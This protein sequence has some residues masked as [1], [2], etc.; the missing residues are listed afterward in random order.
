[1][2]I[3]LDDECEIISCR[4]RRS[5]SSSSEIIYVGCSPTKKSRKKRKQSLKKSD[6]AKTAEGTSLHISDGSENYF[7][8]DQVWSDISSI[9]KN[10]SCI[11]PKAE[12]TQ[13]SSFSATASSPSSSDEEDTRIRSSQEH[14]ETVKLMSNKMMNNQPSP[15]STNSSTSWFASSSTSSDS[16][17]NNDEFLLSLFTEDS[18]FGNNKATTKPTINSVLPADTCEAALHLKETESKPSSTT[19]H[20]R[21]NS[22][23][24]VSTDKYS[25]MSQLALV[26]TDLENL[27]NKCNSLK[28]NFNC[29]AGT[30][31]LSSNDITSE[32]SALSTA[33]FATICNNDD[34]NSKVPNAENFDQSLTKS[35]RNCM[36]IKITLRKAESES[37]SKRK[38]SSSGKRKRADST[39]ALP[40]DVSH[41]KVVDSTV[42]SDLLGS[43]SEQN[44]TE[45]NSSSNGM[46]EQNDSMIFR[47]SV[48]KSLCLH[49]NNIVSDILDGD[50]DDVQM[51]S[52]T[53][54]RKR[55]SMSKMCFAT[56]EDREQSGCASCFS[57][58]PRQSM[59]ACAF[60]HYSCIK[61][62]EYQIKSLVSQ[63]TKVI[64]LCVYLY[65]MFYY[66]IIVIT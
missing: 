52:H 49:D 26:K 29:H 38:N 54:P 62:L 30:S 8:S 51:I 22:D 10:D 9:I 58:F 60:G 6:C 31:V 44:V 45:V 21:I 53:L 42:C 66:D 25:G 7:N 5:S 1:M 41:Y 57:M 28:V 17:E 36:P 20:R 56:D 64:L 12:N 37:L 33:H 34:S 15:T 50:D 48:T 14:I 4:R 16:D 11:Q 23:G 40:S 32:P 18:L 47:D 39:F 3:C 61:C 19:S 27:L 63:T 2:Y 24:D 43:V 46:A 65:S 35:S 59:V 55:S 13:K